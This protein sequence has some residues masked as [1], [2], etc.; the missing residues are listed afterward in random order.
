MGGRF[1]PSSGAEDL[2]GIK[3]VR[4]LREFVTRGTTESSAGCLERHRS[5]R[6]SGNQARRYSVTAI[7]RNAS[8]RWGKVKTDR[9]NPGY[10]ECDFHDAELPAYL[11]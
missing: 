8:R 6:H 5:G 7:Q 9:I 4:G 2:S 3:L 11:S 10:G 1:L